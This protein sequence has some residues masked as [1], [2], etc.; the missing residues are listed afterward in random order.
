M[1]TKSLDIVTGYKC[2]NNCLFCLSPITKPRELSFD[3]I[4]RLLLKYQNKFDKLEFIG[5]EPTI[6]KDIFKI[7]SLARKLGYKTVRIST[8]GRMYA[9]SDFCNK[10][11]KAGSH[12][13]SFSLYGSNEKIHDAAT[14][15]P[16]S[17][18]NTIQGIKNAVKEKDIR[19]VFV[20][21]VIY[22]GNYKDIENI[23]KLLIKLGVKKWQ[24]CDLIPEGL[25]RNL[26]KNLVVSLTDLNALNNIKN[27]ASSF[28]L[29]CFID[30]PHCIFDKATHS[31]KNI[32]ISSISDRTKT[33]QIGHTKIKMFYPGYNEF[34][35]KYKIKPS[36]CQ[37][38][39]LKDSCGGIWKS[40]HQL[41]GEKELK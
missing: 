24:I 14:R 22:K 30:F 26:Y 7:V 17:F 28:D 15:T 2:N 35:Q 33:L 19:E 13:V 4:K 8:N 38:C 27:H 25:A 37:N 11:T 41:F 10:I 9:Y 23:A 18:S 34:E 40:Y 29:I 6:R 31:H 21:T 12:E 5:G 32:K 20:D 39:N 36:I 3:E 16:G 1:E